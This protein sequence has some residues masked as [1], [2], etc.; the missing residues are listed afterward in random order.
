M[1][2]SDTTQ[3]ILAS[4]SASR[5]RMLAAASLDVQQEAP[6]VDEKSV[7]AVLERSGDMPPSDVAEVLARAKAQ[8]VSEKFPAALVIGADQIL[9]AGDKLFEKPRDMEDARR[10]LL[11]L[12]GRT[13]S[14]HAC[15][16]V[17]H[18]GET[19]WTHCGAAS[20]TMRDFTPGFVGLYLAEVGD[21]ALQ[22]V[23]AYQLEGPG[24]H[25]FEKVEGDFF[26]ILGLPLLPLLEFL[27]ERGVVAQ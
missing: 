21:K 20:L 15:V 5:A 25:L 9:V 6:D 27:R 22:S 23:G 17:A 4:T 7:R 10:T 1:L 11:E 12:K 14:L 19:V 24:I 2:N 16:A 8:A 3:L 26:T 13:H 18:G